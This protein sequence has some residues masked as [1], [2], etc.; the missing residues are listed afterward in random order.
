MTLSHWP[1]VSAL[2]D[3]EPRRLCRFSK[4][5]VGTRVAREAGS[6]WDFQ[7]CFSDARPAPHPWMP[8]SPGIPIFFNVYYF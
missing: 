6:T 7:L 5:T 4:V 8:T 1:R 2:A 3:S